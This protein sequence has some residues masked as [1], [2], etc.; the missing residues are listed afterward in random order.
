MKEWIEEPEQH[1]FQEQ[2][3]ILMQQLE[4]IY[5]SQLN[6][7]YSAPPV[8]Q[9]PAYRKRR[10]SNKK[11]SSA[12]QEDDIPNSASM[13]EHGW[14]HPSR[15]TTNGNAN[16]LPDAPRYNYVDEEM[17]QQVQLLQHA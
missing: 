11:Q 16:R 9:N 5:P 12:D 17:A 14:L 7:F 3:Q 2:V 1:S 15:V 6:D 13:V 8:E 4:E 10:K